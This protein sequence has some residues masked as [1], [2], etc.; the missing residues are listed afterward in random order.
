MAVPT[1]QVNY[2]FFSN[3]QKAGFTGSTQAA[4]HAVHACTCTQWGQAQAPR[5]LL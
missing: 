3:R 2:L 1:V 4:L 5:T